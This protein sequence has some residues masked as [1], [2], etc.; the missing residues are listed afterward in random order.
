[1][2]GS[3]EPVSRLYAI[4][5]AE[6]LGTDPAHFAECVVAMASG[7]VRLIQLRLKPLNPALAGHDRLRFDII[8]Q[9]LSALDST[10]LSVGLRSKMQLWLDDRADLA[11]LFPDA[12]AGVHVGQRD[13]PPGGVR[14]VLGEGILIGLSCHDLEEIRTGDKDPDVDWLAVGPVYA[15]RSKPDPD[16]VIGLAGV[17]HIRAATS[18][19]LV[20]I[21]GLTADRISEVLDAGADTAVVLSALVSGGHR[22]AEIE[23][24]A[25][26]L[27]RLAG[28]T[29]RADSTRI[30]EH[31]A[32]ETT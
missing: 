7:G 27:V 8:E 11:A 24:T 4:A 31:K 2:A 15:T 10:G 26:Q 13:L 17:R 3:R 5:D 32:E 23:A 21:G 12:F 19:P 25:R 20:A 30:H 6:C 9:T 22:P 18:K 16:P 28:S 1:M 14:K 29:N